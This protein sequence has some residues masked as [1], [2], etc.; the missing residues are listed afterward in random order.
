[1]DAR[2]LIHRLQGRPFKPFRVHLA[3]GTRL[4]VPQPRMVIVGESRAVL[5]SRFER[6][7]QGRR[8]ARHGRTIALADIIEF[9]DLQPRSNGKGRRRK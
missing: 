1:M 6:D 9:T 5:P 4:D 3:D 2:D 7:E 8:L